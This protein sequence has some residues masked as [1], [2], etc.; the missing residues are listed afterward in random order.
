MFEEKRHI[1]LRLP[2]SWS[3]CSVEELRTVAK[4]LIDCALRATRYKP[5]SITEVKIALF[6]AFT[7]LEIVEP[8]NPHIDVE[9]QF[10]LVRFVDKR[11]HLLRKLWRWCR[12]KI[13]GEDTSVFKLFLWQ[14]AS[15]IDDEKDLNTGRVIRAGL[16][17]WLNCEGNNHLYNF[18]FQEIKRRRS[19]W[20]Q[21]KTFRGPESL[22]QD[23]TWQ[24]YRF[25]QDYMEF[26]VTQQNLLIQMK[27]QGNMV[28][29]DDLQKQEKATDL[30][31]AYFL[32]TLYKAK[33]RVVDENTQGV[34]YDFEYQSNQ[35]A[36]YTP[37]FRNFSEEDWQV[38]RF[39]WEGMMH[40]LQSEY[41]R[42]F[43]KQNVKGQ[44]KQ[45]N[46]LELYTRTTATM[47]KYLGLDEKGV[48]NQFFQI[49]LQ[50]MDNMARENEELEKIRSS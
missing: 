31:R 4:V 15:W 50:H 34:R 33:T 22:M 46:P 10:Y 47:Q 20:R 21:K 9:H 5:F 19:W 43:K 8:V 11:F 6:F 39:W 28:S 40:Y 48:N 38:I 16:L 23:F 7:G 37:Y 41:P 45:A 1:N 42:C 32:A 17:D 35:V 27:E 18:P 3:D 2:T 12:K 49:V 26:Y 24:R 13:T 30:S 25:L 44:Q 29:V 36:D 14:I